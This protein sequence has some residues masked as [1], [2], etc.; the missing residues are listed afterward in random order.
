MVHTYV[1]C[2]V[3]EK[4][5]KYGLTSLN[6]AEKIRNIFKKDHPILFAFIC[7]VGPPGRTGAWPYRSRLDR[8]FP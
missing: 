2:K 6:F 1:P 8:R 7:L 5:R 3:P 4:K